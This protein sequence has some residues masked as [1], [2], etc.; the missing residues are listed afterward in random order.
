EAFWSN[1]MGEFMLKYEDVI[2][3]DAP[4]KMLHD[5]FNSTYEATVKTSNWDTSKLVK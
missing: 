2:A 5:F 1:E 3:S 4:E